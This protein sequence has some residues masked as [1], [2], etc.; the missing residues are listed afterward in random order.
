MSI[1]TAL[2][3]PALK[4]D[5]WDLGSYAQAFYTTV[6]DHRLF[7]YTM[8]LPNNP[9]G[10]LFG[11]HFTPFMFLL[12]PFFVL[13]PSPTT[14][15]VIQAM[16]VGGG[17]IP[18]FLL[19]RR[20]G[21]S[22]RMSSI[23]A[24]AYLVNPLVIGVNWFDFHPEA[25]LLPFLLVACYCWEVRRWFGFAVAIA[26]ALSTIE[27]AGVLVATLGTFWTVDIFL[28]NRRLRAAISRLDF[29]VAIL[30][31]F[32]GLS[33]F[34]IGI[35]MVFYVNPANALISGGTGFWRVLGAASV[36]DVPLRSLLSPLSLIAAL[37]VDW[38]SKVGF[39]LLLLGFVAFL[40]ALRPLS[41]ILLLPWLG[42][43]L[44]SNNP[45]FY[46]AGN[47]YPALVV[48][49]VFYG[50][51][52][53]L[54]RLMPPSESTA[55]IDVG[56]DGSSPASR[57]HRRRTISAAALVL[58]VLISISIPINEFGLLNNI[59]SSLPFS[60]R[61]ENA[62]LA[63]ASLVPRTESILTQNNLFPLF[64]DRSNAYVIPHSTYFSPGASFEGTFTSYLNRSRYALVDLRTSLVEAG[65]VLTHSTDL[66]A[67]GVVASDDGAILLGRGFSGPPSSFVPSN[68]LFDWQ[69]LMLLGGD[70]VSDPAAVSGSALIHRPG[71]GPQFWNMAGVL[72]WPGTYTVGFRLRVDPIVNGTV[73]VVGATV[74]PIII[75]VATS[76]SAGG[77]TSVRLGSSLSNNQ[78][79]LTSMALTGP[80]FV[81]STA[82]REFSIRFSTTVFGIYRFLGSN[83]TSNATVYLDQMS[84]REEAPLGSYG[85]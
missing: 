31:T 47:Q 75:S 44:A 25:F 50:A 6:F 9:S 57:F 37:L 61:H 27:V 81:P 12:L 71:D 83:I 80:A 32:V 2:R 62:V 42:P 69:N 73:L 28:E 4:A 13:V 5:A 48:A 74:Q 64:Y 55:Q 60:G 10:S 59:P 78:T 15:L 20:R 29:Q 11:A 1:L 51:A 16:A 56:R 21:L 76:L 70:R 33:W 84:V 38:P 39:L 77:V 43:A 30:L 40:P 22:E 17:G 26:L 45:A 49:F 53:G 54:Q 79:N 19:G 82:Y 72:L 35:R 68:W 18:I 34:W 36:V 14:L 58:A 7:Y 63:I 3:V 24:F 66:R 67:F 52:M 85:P 65:F 8:D 46:S 41:L 23:L